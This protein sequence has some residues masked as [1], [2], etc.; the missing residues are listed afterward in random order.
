MKL[1]KKQNTKRRFWLFIALGFNFYCFII[2]IDF[3]RF[4]VS[5]STIVVLR[6]CRRHGRSTKYTLQQYI[7]RYRTTMFLGRENNKLRVIFQWTEHNNRYR[8]T[9]T[10]TH[11][12]KWIVFGGKPFHFH[13]FAV[14]LCVRKLI[15]GFAACGLGN[16]ILGCA[17]TENSTNV[18]GIRKSEHIIV[19]FR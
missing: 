8:F 12:G 18:P 15:I 1:E 14:V 5:R 17:R 16:A 19:V 4:I 13:T 2:Y 6:Q 11:N 3:S 7:T 9:R 10:Y